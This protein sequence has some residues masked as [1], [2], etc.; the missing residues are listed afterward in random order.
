MRSKTARRNLSLL[1]SVIVVILLAVLL[2]AIAWIFIGFA[3]YGEWTT[4]LPRTETT[5]ADATRLV[6]TITAGIGAAVALVVAY[7]RQRNLEEGRFLERLA[8]A[9]RQIGDREPIVQF[10]GLYALVALANE[11]SATAARQT[12]RRQQCVSVLCAY[13]RLPYSE[14]AHESLIEEVVHKQTWTNSRGNIEETRTYGVRPADREVRRTIIRIISENLQPSASITW[15]N[16]S[17]DFHGVVF[18]VGDFSGAVFSGPRTDFRNAHFTTGNV[19]FNEAQFTGGNTYFN[20]AHFTSGN[21]SFSGAQF[22]GGN[23]DFGNAQF[24]GGDVYFNDAQFTGSHVSFSGSYFRGGAVD[25][26]GARFDAGNIYFNSTQFAGSE[27]DFSASKFAGATVNFTAS[28]FSNGIVN[29]NSSEFIAGDVNF[30]RA[31][32]TGAGVY[33]RDTDFAAGAVYFRDTRFTGG[34]IYFCGARF[35]GSILNF[36]RAEFA[37]TVI[38]FGDAHFAGGAVGF[39][40]A[41][42]TGGIVDF[43]E[44]TGADPGILD[45]NNPSSWDAPPVVPWTTGRV[46]SWGHPAIWPPVAP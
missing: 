41:R 46:P 39:L 37:G 22:T 15:S 40:H 13:L 8:T 42:F 11:P 33:F 45:F 19:F 44:A 3:L 5:R 12:D 29:F 27:V 26:S 36:H 31:E 2:T 28:V 34:T 7:R 25:F 43:E 32:F 16:L 20:A 18:D 35:T 6:L 23:V 14:G 17:L 10:S 21:V 9:A 38:K 30:S 4:A 24:T 1:S